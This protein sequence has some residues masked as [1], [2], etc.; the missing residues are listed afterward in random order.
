[1]ECAVVKHAK[2]PVIRELIDALIG[3]GRSVA[4]FVNFR[5][6]MEE[7]KEIH[8]VRGVY[9]HGEQGVDDHE[10]AVE[11]SQSDRV[12]LIVLNSEAGGASMSFHDVPGER[13]RYSIINPSWVYGKN[14]LPRK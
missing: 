2:L 3:E 8:G 12:H 4:V 1:L 10:R 7:L 11:L 5:A 14:H 13:P 9:V 6:S